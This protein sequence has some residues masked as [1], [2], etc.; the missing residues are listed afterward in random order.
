MVDLDTAVQFTNDTVANNTVTTSTG[1]AFNAPAGGL[2]LTA[3]VPVA[4]KNT[5]V[6]TTPS[7]ANCDTAGHTGAIG[8]AGGNIDSGVSCGFSRPG[9]QYGTN[10]MV[11]PVANNSGPVETASLQAGSPAIGRGVTAG[12]RR[13]TPGACA[14]PKGQIDVGAFQA[15]NQGYWMVASD[16]GIFTFGTAGFHGSEGGVTLNAPVVGMAVTPD[17][18]RLLG[19]GRRRRGLH[20][21]QRHL[22]RLDGLKHLNAPIVGMAAA[23]TGNGYWLVASDGGIFA[24][25][26]ALFHGSKG[27]QHLNAPVV[28]IAADPTGN[29]YWE[30]ASD[31]GIFNYGSAGF[32]GSKGGQHLNA[33]VVGIAPA[34][35]GNGYWVVASDG[36]VFN[37]G[38]RRLLRLQG[39]PAPERPHGRHRRHPHRP[40]LLGVRLRRRGLHLRHRHL[41]GLDGGHDPQRPGGRWGRPHEGLGTAAPA[42]ARRRTGGGRWRGRRGRP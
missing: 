7:T 17:R 32:F 33:P 12:A 20:L 13:P 2:V 3:T 5:I 34:P 35:T 22:L 28:G 29:G 16:G 26:S 8:S 9:D 6:A 30:V 36:G 10:P 23:P 39:R 25:G 15:S 37:Y 31:G 14:R 27:G 24:F 41:L 38:R 42:N 4:L 40:G 19:G 1:G 21:R 11:N 18:R